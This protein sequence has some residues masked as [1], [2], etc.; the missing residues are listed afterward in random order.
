MVYNYKYNINIF[1]L[2][3]HSLEIAETKDIYFVKKW[4]KKCKKFIQKH[5]VF[6]RY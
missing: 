4:L 3:N 5:E 6:S 1:F 2:N